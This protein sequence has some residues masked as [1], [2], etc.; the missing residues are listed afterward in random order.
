MVAWGPALRP[1]PSAMGLPQYEIDDVPDFRRRS[2]LGVAL[3]AL[4]TLTPFSVYNFLQGRHL[5]AIGSLAIVVILTFNAW[6]I[7]QG[8][9]YPLTLFGLVPAMAG[10][11]AYTVHDLGMIGVLWCYPV[12]LSFYF[13][14]PERMAWAANAILLALALPQAWMVVDHPMVARVIA[15]LLATSAFSAIFVRVISVQQERLHALAVKDHLTGL[16][17]RTLFDATLDQAIE[18]HRRTGT[19]MTLV[20]LDL[21]HFKAIND[22]LGHGAG[23]DVLRGLGELLRKRV[24]RSDK[25]FRLGGE[26]FVVLLYGTGRENGQRFAEELRLAV[27]SHGFLPKRQVTASL[28]VATLSNG[29]TPRSWLKR[30]DDNLYRAKAAGRNR[31]EV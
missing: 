18:Q 20:A 12:V 1:D 7:R 27:E 13:I 2:S 25:A 11:L 4:A 30:A 23:D 10:F 15:T 24:R 9:Y 29:E 16:A 3:T 31:V 8:R 26:E 22:S 6:S 17:N 21:D 14:L 19:D 28:G 5:F